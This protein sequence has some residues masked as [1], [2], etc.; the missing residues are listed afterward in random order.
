MFPSPNSPGQYQQRRMSPSQPRPVY[1]SHIGNPIP[2]HFLPAPPFPCASKLP[3]ITS[4][5][6]ALAEGLHLSHP[7]H[8]SLACRSQ[9]FVPPPGLPLPPP[10][11]PLPPP[12]MN[13][14]HLYVATLLGALQQPTVLHVRQSV[15]HCNLNTNQVL[16]KLD[17]KALFDKD[18]SG[19]KASERKCKI[20]QNM[21]QSGECQEV[22]RRRKLDAQD[23]VI[24]STSNDQDVQEQ[25]DV[26]EPSRTFPDTNNF[27][28]LE[29]QDSVIGLDRAVT[30]TNVGREIQGE[31]KLNGQDQ[32][33]TSLSYEES[34]QDKP[35][36]RISKVNRKAQ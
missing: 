36:P 21:H 27:P 5:K 15:S 12:S 32:V 29:N 8:P 18:V 22:Q 7:L 3:K 20:V 33:T 4:V 25:G 6:N 16:S 10:G 11:L 24:C 14:S 9:H 35:V 13:N 28:E 30:D 2:N 17:L 19:S 31:S 23:T 1:Y 34:S 26:N